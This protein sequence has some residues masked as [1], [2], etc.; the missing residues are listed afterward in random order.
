MPKLTVLAMTQ[1]ILNDMDSDEVN[2][3]NDTTEALQIAQILKTT[4]YEILGQ[5]T[6]PHTASLQQLTASGTASRPT[7]MTIATDVIDVEWVKYNKKTAVVDMDSYDII[8]YKTPE[9]FM[10]LMDSRDSTLTNVDTIVDITGVTLRIITDQ[11]PDYYTSFDDETLIFDSYYSTL[12]NTLQG[13][14]TQVW[15]YKE[16]PFSLLDGFIPDLPTK[17]FSYYLAEAK[18]TAFNALKQAP[19]AKEE[20]R[21]RRQKRKLSRT[22]NRSGGGGVVFPNYGRK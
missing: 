14:K 22:M 15:G 2:S 4:Y 17:A 8:N 18:S 20:Q 7:H 19:N 13:S 10:E 6:W 5:R 11:Q 12:D 16:P 21:V 9:D 1:D 3:I